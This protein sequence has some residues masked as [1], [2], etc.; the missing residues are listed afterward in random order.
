MV[1]GVANGYFDSQ[2]CLSAQRPCNYAS[3]T[4]PLRDRRIL[5]R[6]AIPPG[7]QAPWELAN[8]SAIVDVGLKA[9]TTMDPFDVLP[10]KMP[11]KSQ[12]LYR[13]CM[14]M[15]GAL[16]ITLLTRSTVDFQSGAPFAVAPTDP[17]DDWFVSFSFISLFSFCFSVPS[18]FHIQQNSVR[19]T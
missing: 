4:V 14:F 2:K 10:I 17:K 11:F 7:Q 13:Y 9:G 18:F 5:Q 19:C 1:Y 8:S 12:E 15:A 6:N 16:E 3:V